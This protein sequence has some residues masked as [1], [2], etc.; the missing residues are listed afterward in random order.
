MPLMQCELFNAEASPVPRRVPT[1]QDLVG[2]ASSQ[3]TRAVTQMLS[4]LSR[5][6]DEARTTILRSRF[7]GQ[8]ASEIAAFVVSGDPVSRVL[9][10]IYNRALPANELVVLGPVWQTFI[11]WAKSMGL[12]ASI[13]PAQ[14]LNRGVEESGMAIK[15]R[16]LA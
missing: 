10:G 13:E 9:K 12:A 14:R 7:A 5:V 2:L 1:V 6:T 16:P 3:K 4:G 11:S 8:E 15:V